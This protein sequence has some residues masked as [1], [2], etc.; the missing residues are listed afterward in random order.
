MRVGL[1]LS[2]KFLFVWAGSVIVALAL[3]GAFSSYLLGQYHE[4]VAR[5]ALETSFKQIESH[6]RQRD[7]LLED[8]VT[9]LAGDRDL[10]AITNLLN[11]YQDKQNYQPLTFDTEKKKAARRL[12]EQG[13]FTGFNYIALYM[14]GPE[15]VAYT[16]R[17][18]SS[19]GISGIV[20]YQAGAP[21]FLAGRSAADFRPVDTVPSIG[22]E[23]APGKFPGAV[24][25]AF[26]VVSGVL[27]HSVTAPI[28]RKR[29][30]G[31]DEIIGAIVAVDVLG[32]QFIER[33]SQ[34]IGH[35]F[36]IHFP[37]TKGSVNLG[38]LLARP[39]EPLPDLFDAPGGF[40]WLPDSDNYVGG[41]QIG[42][43]KGSRAALLVSVGRQALATG[44]D[45]IQKAI[46][47]VLAVI[48]LVVLPLGAYFIRRNLTEPI[49]KLMSGV[50]A[51]SHD[52]KNV[53]ISLD[54]GDELDALAQ[55]F[56]TMSRTIG[57]REEDLK[58]SR[59]QL[60]LITDNLPM[61][62]LYSDRQQK[63]RFVNKVCS[64]WYARPAE[65][66]LGKSV[67]DLL[68]SEYEKVR[69]LIKETIEGKRLTYNATLTYPD[70]V[71]RT[72]RGNYLPHRGQAGKIEGYFSIVEDITDRVRAEEQLR[73][74]QKMEAVG[75]LT[76]GIAHD[77]NNLLAVILGNAELLLS[78]EG[79]DK[80]EMT[81]T[82]IDATA[83]GAELTQRL[84]AFSRKQ[85]LK[86][87]SLDIPALVSRMSELLKRTLGAT[88][89][90]ETVTA[91]DLWNAL[92]D[93]G[94]VEN[95]LLNL[96]INSRDAMPNGGKLTIKC[97]NARLDEEYAA[98][99]PESQAGDYVVL[100]VTDTGTGISAEIQPRV[101]EPF[102][103][104]KKVGEGSGLGLSM[105]YGFAKQSGG[106]IAMNSVVGE[107]TTMKL[108]L[109][110]AEEG[111]GEGDVESMT[112]VP[113]G[114]GELI[115]V[116]EDDV[117]VGR[118]VVRMLKALD[119]RVIDVPAAARARKILDGDDKVDLVLT[120]VVLPGGISGP[121]FAKE[122]CADHPGLKVVFMS[123]YP[124]DAAARSGFEISGKL[125][126]KPFRKEDVARVL[127]DALDRAP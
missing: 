56:N 32:G 86:P 94:Q 55:A 17:E 25:H 1:S 42:T 3:V 43:S 74:A 24:E 35:A 103:T 116:I 48:A 58:S 102:F 21:L 4:T 107:G 79:D 16:Y 28:V 60:R 37:D 9:G 104:T 5:Q 115:L 90:V 10:I 105:I 126:S 113:R 11:K 70:G 97:D 99:N 54:S 76:G 127:R 109:P 14:N 6:L 53:E 96:A 91:P 31:A 33:T 98:L 84:L 123:G 78:E 85:P 46:V 77:F 51:L 23:V 64:E 65:E 82:V 2:K 38:K 29:R 88:I 117:R 75:Q 125:L 36:S 101:F 13:N 62:I 95:A 27:V 41:A 121:E 44:I 108:F 71:T 15:L 26:N 73:Q 72:V 20:S 69:H 106:H 112:D 18:Q 12:S 45:A 22:E 119:Y 63:Y 19:P 83:R 49:S 7:T 59:D 122:A 93:P 57:S 68:G 110:R 92:A 100:A 61:M 66:I 87:Q 89:S 52:E 67:E 81:E 50:T 120:D 111:L 39:A 124:A 30:E 114:R 40:L 118:M 47:A 80:K 34:L 8:L